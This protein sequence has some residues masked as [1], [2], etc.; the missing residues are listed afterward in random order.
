[1][2]M[3]FNR[4]DSVFVHDGTGI[5]YTTLYRRVQAGWELNKILS[6]VGGSTNVI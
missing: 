5:R 2:K 4:L 1:M 6:P 3:S